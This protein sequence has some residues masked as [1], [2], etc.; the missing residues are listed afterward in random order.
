MAF[1]RKTIT[2]MRETTLSFFSVITVRPVRQTRDSAAIWEIQ[3]FHGQNT[4]LCRVAWRYLFETVRFMSIEI[5]TS[6]ESTK[7]LMPSRYDDPNL[8][9]DDYRNE[10]AENNGLFSI[11]ATI[12]RREKK[13]L[14]DL[15]RTTYYSATRRA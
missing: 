14:L 12:G 1:A 7:S 2:E 13:H 3:K 9:S 4:P 15:L 10:T 6:P 11:I 5:Q 8:K